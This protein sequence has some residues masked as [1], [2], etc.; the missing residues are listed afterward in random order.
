[1]KNVQFGRETNSLLFYIKIKSFS[2]PGNSKKPYLRD[3]LIITECKNHLMTAFLN[4]SN[5]WAR[6]KIKKTKT[7][8]FDRVINALSSYIKTENF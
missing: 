8:W 4:V 5:F 1:M 3:S 2:T 7:I 6:F